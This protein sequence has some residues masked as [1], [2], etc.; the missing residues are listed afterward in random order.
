M[1]C[2]VSRQRR[3]WAAAVMVLAAGFARAED[4][5]PTPPEALPPAM[6]D[7]GCSFFEDAKWAA[8]KMSG[9][10]EPLRIVVTAKGDGSDSKVAYA[11]SA[12]LA[13]GPWD[14]RIGAMIC[15]NSDQI[16]CQAQFFS[17]DQ[18]KGD[19]VTVWANHFMMLDEIGWKKKVSS[20]IVGC[21]VPK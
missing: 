2:G 11:G 14:R 12:N 15:D 21:A 3:A 1:R 10:G 19:Q 6:H 8:D 4:L 7:K 18:K 13:G 9:I 16:R 5:N 17:E 20:L